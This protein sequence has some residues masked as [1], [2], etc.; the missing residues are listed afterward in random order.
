M[1]EL[2]GLLVSQLGVQQNQAAGGAG[3]LLKL[4]QSKLGGDFSKISA[5]IPD[6]QKLISSTPKDPV[7]GG[8]M[9]LAGSLASSLGGAKAG[10]LAALAGGFGQLK[11]TPDMIGK[12]V[13]VLLSFAKSK[14]GADVM[15]LLAG[16][17][18]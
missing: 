1:N 8:L 13:P 7:G 16:V 11:L 10:Q 12:F 17:L 14:G 9:G 5:V 18:K 6:A 3:L 15:Q 4:A 2:V